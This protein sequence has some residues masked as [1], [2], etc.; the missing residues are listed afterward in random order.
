MGLAPGLQ[1]RAGIEVSWTCKR[2]NNSRIRESR[3]GRYKDAFSV[4]ERGFSWMHLASR[5]ETTLN[6]MSRN[7]KN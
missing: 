2:R 3:G 4:K 6:R 1:K 7:R 5:F